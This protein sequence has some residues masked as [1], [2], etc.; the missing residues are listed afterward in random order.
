MA[1]SEKVFELLKLHIPPTRL[2][3]SDGLFLDIPEDAQWG[4]YQKLLQA[5][6][7]TDRNAKKTTMAEALQ[8]FNKLHNHKLNGTMDEGVWAR[9]EAY[10]LKLWL[11][12][13]RECSRTMRGGGRLCPELRVLS[14]GYLAAIHKVGKMT[15]GT[16]RLLKRNS[17]EA[18]AGAPLPLV[19]TTK[20][21]EPQST[22]AA[23]F[24]LYGKPAPA[25]TSSSIIDLDSSQEVSVVGHKEAPSSSVDLSS[26]SKKEQCT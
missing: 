5:L 12:R 1:T 7:A 9:A 10:A 4:L 20:K 18:G 22:R 16:R 21:A 25:L 19:A 26:P 15:R 11:M 23:I 2:Q 17:S 6:V 13:I 14:E 24:A 3:G 8:R